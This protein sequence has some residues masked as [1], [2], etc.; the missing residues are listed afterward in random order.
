M[1]RRSAVRWDL[2]RGDHCLPSEP[3][4]YRTVRQRLAGCSC[5]QEEGNEENGDRLRE[6]SK[7]KVREKTLIA[8]MRQS[9]WR[10]GNDG[11]MVMME[12][13]RHDG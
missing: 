5:L 6:G 1:L 12:T 13:W 3:G 7:Q 4:P 11:D 10:H 9:W 8:V 2:Q